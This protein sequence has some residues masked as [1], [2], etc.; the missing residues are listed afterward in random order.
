MDTLI[1]AFESLDAGILLIDQEHCIQWMNGKATE[2]LGPL[3]LGKKRA[4]YRTLEYGNRFCSICPTGETIDH[5]RF[6]RYELSLQKSRRCTLDITGLP[7]VNPGGGISMV[8]EIIVDITGKDME[9]RKTSLLDIQAVLSDTALCNN[10]NGIN[11]Y[12][13]IVGKSSAIK[14]LVQQIRTVKDSTLPVL[15]T[16]ESG[17]GKE[18]VAKALHFDS[19]RKDK[20]FI[21]I[22]CASLKPELLENEL[23]GHVKGAFTGAIA[24]KDGLLKAADGGT[25]FI[26]EI[27]DMNPVVQ[28]SLLR[29]LETGYFRPLGSTKE[30]KVSVRIIAAINRNI[31]DEIKAMRFRHDLY[32][33]LNVCRIDIRPLR[34]RKE[35]IPLLAGHF[36]FTSPIAK[37]KG[38]N[39]LSP[40]ALD[41][42]QLYQWPGNVRELFNLLGRAALVCDGRVITKKCLLRH[43]PSTDTSLVQ[44]SFSSIP[45]SLNELE[46]QYI[47]NTVKACGRN[48]SRAARMLGIDRRTLYRKMEKYSGNTNNHFSYS[49]S[50]LL[51]SLK[52]L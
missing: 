10:S 29:F 42:L 17:T 14:H 45:L 7:I 8:M 30:T 25:F 27:A 37:D 9:K 41:L 16:G 19:V 39:I 24:N 43:I 23:F 32:Y 50:S 28:A 20:P 12:M 5:G 3:D 46:Q 48:I 21:A 18:L 33:R 49:S 15:I 40:D 4:C 52:A 36:L 38:I 26:D 35:D 1:H 34:N 11:N 31:E 22:N 44:G 47:E 51:R 6:T 13:G 2:L